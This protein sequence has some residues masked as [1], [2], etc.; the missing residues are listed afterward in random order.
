MRS[1]FLLD[2]DWEYEVLVLY[3][4]TAYDIYSY[5]FYIFLGHLHNKH[6]S[7]NTYKQLERSENSVTNAKG[8]I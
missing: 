3:V 5:H 4:T 1:C 6:V 8:R 2:M 7:D